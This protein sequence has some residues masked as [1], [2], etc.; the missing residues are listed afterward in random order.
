MFCLIDNKEIKEKTYNYIF[1]LCDSVS[2]L[3][4]DYQNN[5]NM[6]QVIKNT[7]YENIFNNP[8]SSSY[9]TDNWNMDGFIYKY[10]LTRIT[11]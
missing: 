2:F 8:I 1:S 11:Q 3:Y 6:E 7:K 10:N 5:T 4:V 9:K